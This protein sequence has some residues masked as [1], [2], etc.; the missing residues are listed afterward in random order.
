MLLE[1]AARSSAANEICVRIQDFGSGKTMLAKRL[2]GIQPPLDFSE[3]LETTQVHSVAGT[4][5]PNAGLLH[6]RRFRART[7]RSPT[8]AFSAAASASRAPAR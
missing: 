5:A 7:T 3:A 8:S 2:P 1:S 6:E 4:L